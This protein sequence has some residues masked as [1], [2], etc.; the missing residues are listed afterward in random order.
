MRPA[1]ATP[2][3]LASA[4]LLACA[5]PARVHAQPAVR[6]DSTRLSIDR[7]FRRSEFA[8]TPGPS[9]FWLRDGRSYLSTRAAAGGGADILR[10]DLATGRS[11]VLAP[12]SALVDARGRRLDVEDIQLSADE[13]RA[14]LFHSSVRV[15]RSNTRGAYHVLDFATRRLTPIAVITTPG[16]GASTTTDTMPGDYLGRNPSFLARGLASGAVDADLQMFA[17][18]SPDGRQVAYVRG[19]NLWVADAATGRARQLTTDGSDDVINGTTDWV[20]E[21]ELG[22]RDAFRWSPDS[23]RIAFWRFDQRA[24]PAFPVVNETEALYPSV[25]VLRYPKAGAP[26]SR[27]T[28]GVLDAAGGGATRWLEVG[29][30]TGQYIA[31]MEWADADSLAIQRLPRKQDRMDLLMVSATSGRGRTVLTERDSAYV[32]IEGEAV[33]WI[34][35]GRR[36]LLRSDRTGWRQIF[37]YDRSGS[38]V[39]QVTANG[40]DVVDVAA[41]DEARGHLYVIAA[42]PTPTQRQV[43]RYALGTAR[44]ASAAGERITTAGGTHSLNIGPDARYAVDTYSSLGRPAT[45]TLFEL[46]AMRPVRVL[47]NNA[48]LDA[49][50]AALDV[51]RPEFI[52]VPMPDGTILDG[53]RIVPARFD[54]TRRHP[55]LMHL[56]GGPASPRVNDA[57]GG[58]DYLWHQMLA[59]N[60]YVV[61][62]VDNR[63]AAWRGR[64]FRK[65]TQFRLGVQESQDQIDAARWVGRQPW[66]DRARIGMWGWSYGGYMTAL[67]LARG[68]EVFKAGISVAPVVD[69]RYYDTI[70]TERFMW[71]PQRNPEG[72]K[73]TARL[74]LVHGTGDDNVHPQNAMV[75]ADAL[76]RAEK[77]FWMLLYPNRTHSISGGNTQAHLFESFTRFVLE[78]L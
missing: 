28:V 14:L 45:V 1:S 51:V 2:L 22:L 26:N 71:T 6:A 38:L 34:E 74:L 4:A 10:V 11:T 36:F 9:I 78:N 12:A 21:E 61:V 57:Y 18:F 25:S 65:V 32:D 47:E 41:V 27:V 55:V 58:R 53:Y 50:L 30:D 8:V 5:M 75:L 13:S 43:Y 16:T 56:Y 72:Y 7:I 60:G 64:S 3:A 54:S 68:G 73:A 76:Q 69:W 15:W 40:S 33:T 66:A 67:T 70:Y 31:R 23:R 62:V 39:R 59:Q 20:Y 42:A 63:G 24:V 77:P 46:P 17:K 48:A 52:K 19:N 37:L 44:G 35:G 29:P 49:K